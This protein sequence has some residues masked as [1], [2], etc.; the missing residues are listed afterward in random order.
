MSA[1]RRQEA[2]ARFSVP[3]EEDHLG[4]DISLTRSRRTGDA[5]DYMDAADTEFLDDEDEDCAFS[6]KKKKK[7]S[8][9]KGR[10][11]TS[12]G[13]HSV[14]GSSFTEENPKVMLL[15]LKAVCLRISHWRCPNN[16]TFREHLAST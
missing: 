15:S 5:D 13:R 2:I 12:S 11:S 3:L 14:D 10:A 7:K 6:D 4:V 9:G 16:F 1:K 8:K